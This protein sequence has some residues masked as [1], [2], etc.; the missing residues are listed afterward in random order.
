VFPS[1]LSQGSLHSGATPTLCDK[2]NQI[3]EWGQ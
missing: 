2:L 1:R 3:S